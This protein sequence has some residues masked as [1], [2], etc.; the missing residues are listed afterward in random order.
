MQDI[1]IVLG[2]PKRLN[3]TTDKRQS[4]FQRQLRLDHLVCPLTTH[5]IMSILEISGTA[6][7]FLEYLLRFMYCR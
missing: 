4:E 1:E 2:K 5:D 3:K 7:R 6:I